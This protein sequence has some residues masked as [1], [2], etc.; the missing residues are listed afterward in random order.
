MFCDVL[1]TTTEPSSFGSVLVHTGNQYE[2]VTFCKYSQLVA[3]F[4]LVRFFSLHVSGDYVPIIRRNNC[5]YAT[6]GNCYSV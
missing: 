3:Q 1:I 2:K 4:S 5:I 6:L